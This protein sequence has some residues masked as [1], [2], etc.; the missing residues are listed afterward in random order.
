MGSVTWAMRN[1]SGGGFEIKPREEEC[2]EWSRG[3]VRREGGRQTRSKISKSNLPVARPAVQHG[4]S[5]L[6]I[7]ARAR[8]FWYPPPRRRRRGAEARKS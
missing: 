3:M 6:A 4:K 5:A 1:G 2:E 8:W 7:E